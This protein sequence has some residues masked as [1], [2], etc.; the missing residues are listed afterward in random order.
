MR[1]LLIGLLAASFYIAAEAVICP[2]GYKAH[3]GSCFQ[4]IQK[5]STWYKAKADCVHRGRSATGGNW[6]GQLA[7]PRNKITFKFLYSLV[8]GRYGDPRFGAW[9]GVKSYRIGGAFRFVSDKKKVSRRFKW[10]PGEPNEYNSMDA[11]VLVWKA[12]PSGYHDNPCRTY[13]GLLNYYHI[14][15]LIPLKTVRRRRYCSNNPQKWIPNTV[16]PTLFR[17]FLGS[18]VRLTCR[19]G[20][21]RDRRF[22]VVEVRCTRIKGKKRPRW[23]PCGACKEIQPY[24]RSNPSG[25]VKN[26]AVPITGTF[27][28]TIGDTATLQ[29]KVGYWSKHRVIAR[30]VARS[31]REGEWS[32]TSTCTL[33]QKYCN[34]HPN[35]VVP[36]SNSPTYKFSRDLGSNVNINCWKGYKPKFGSVVRVVCAAHKPKHGVWITNNECREIPKYCNNHPH[37][38]FRNVL[39]ARH[40]SYARSLGSEV[41]LSC[42]YGFRAVTSYSILARCESWTVVDGAWSSRQ[43][44]LPIPRYCSKYPHR[45]VSNSQTAKVGTFSRTVGS[46]VNINCKPGF[47]AHPAVA[48]AHV[49]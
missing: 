31:A 41:R 48:R 24:C 28:R 33:I 46:S 26:S 39:A 11:C 40:G 8:P 17:R 38:S 32:S 27:S 42:F 13:P 36:R 7:E 30:C 29:C 3:K 34:N 21:E 10:S 49:V 1:F 4:V 2:A 14:C 5:S 18:H 47:K 16:R 37:T 6:V 45:T 25:S 20:Y 23:V 43:T 12:G 35:G 15:Q 9:V 44:C 22:K 19:P